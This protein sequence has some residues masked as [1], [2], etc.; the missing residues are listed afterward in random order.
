[1]SRNRPV[2]ARHV[3]L[4]RHK[5]QPQ[6]P[7]YSISTVCSQSSDALISVDY[8]C[9]RVTEANWIFSYSAGKWKDL[10]RSCGI[11]S[12]YVEEYRFTYDS[13][14]IRVLANY[15]IYIESWVD[16]NVVIVGTSAKGELQCRMQGCGMWTDVS[17]ELINSWLVISLDVSNAP[18]KVFS[19]IEFVA[20]WHWKGYSTSCWVSTH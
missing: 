2:Y 12:E 13:S 6:H 14:G 16:W 8:G 18:V 7:N 11:L 17:T 4:S 5:T 15:F 1:M 10:K 20:R 9:R 19:A 3:L